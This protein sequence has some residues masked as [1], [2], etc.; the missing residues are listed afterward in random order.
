LGGGVIKDNSF[1]DNILLIKWAQKLV[2]LE[3]HDDCLKL[4]ADASSNNNN[5]MDEWID[6]TFDSIF[7][8]S[9]EEAK[10]KIMPRSE[11]RV[12]VLEQYLR[13]AL[14]QQEKWSDVMKWNFNRHFIKWA[15][16]EFLRAKHGTAVQDS[17]QTYPK[18]RQSPQ[19]SAM[20]SRRLSGMFQFV[21]GSTESNSPASN[22]TITLPSTSLVE[23]AL[24]LSE[25]KKCK[26]PKGSKQYVQELATRL[27]G[28]IIE[29]RRGAMRFASIPPEADVSTLSLEE[30]LE[31]AGGHVA[32]CGP[33][34]ALCEERDIYQ[35]WTREYVELLANYLLKRTNSFSGTTIVLDVGAGDGILAKSI[36]LAMSREIRGESASNGQS[37]AS[38][39]RGGQLGRGK[40]TF[41]A[42][43][44]QQ[45][46]VPAIIAVDD[47]SWSISKK[48]SVEKMSVEEALTTYCGNNDMGQDLKNGCENKQ[49][50]V[51]CSWMPM[52]VDW[53]ALFR[54]ALVDEY[55][56]IGECDD[57]SCGDNW[58]TWGNHSFLSDDVEELLDHKETATDAAESA[59]FPLF[60]VDGYTRIDIDDL[61]PYQFSRF[62]SAVSKTGKTV[63]FRRK[64]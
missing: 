58:K 10:R 27:G 48:A 22:A 57:G 18:L 41:T 32:H 15:R 49:V 52:G 7:G 28:D 6:R 46:K 1:L 43:T 26:V 40:K 59:V 19:L 29:L 64:K 14:V 9:A 5:S 36:E 2:S 16:T 61:L 12:S 62:D 20:S 50:I 45:M 53:S 3:V 4:M 31:L 56:L 35:F 8:A 42:P 34:N 39:Q 44:R 33:L 17:L 24:H 23:K 25:W 51:L 38:K 47:G 37:K 55:I 54:Q 60:E 11:R 21:Q 13:P 30:I 63:A